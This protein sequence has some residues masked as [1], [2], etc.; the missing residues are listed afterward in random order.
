[1]SRVVSSLIGA[2]RRFFGPVDCHCFGRFMIIMI[3]VLAYPGTI[4][5]DTIE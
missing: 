2:F 3:F 1:M 5:L 4:E